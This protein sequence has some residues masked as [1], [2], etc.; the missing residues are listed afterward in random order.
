MESTV[1]IDTRWFRDRL[2]DKQISQR[3]LAGL[4]H[5]DPAAVSLMIRGKRK[6]RAN[7][8]A[9]IARFL[10]V[11]PAE[12]VVRAGG[13]ATIPGHRSRAAAMPFS[14]AGVGRGNGS[15]DV[16]KMDATRSLQRDM[17]DLPVPLSDGGVAILKLP[18]RLSKGDA[19]RIAALVMAFGLKE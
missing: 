10:G 8:V 6:M 18:A 2:A 13:D 19:E 12:V 15:D 16:Q 5:L 14:R 17:L 1:K 7:E 4:M 11:D 9:D 3:K